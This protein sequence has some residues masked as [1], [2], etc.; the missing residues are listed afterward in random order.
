MLVRAVPSSCSVMVV[1]STIAY[2]HMLRFRALLPFFLKSDPWSL[3]QN[4]G[5]N[6]ENW[7]LITE[8]SDLL[9]GRYI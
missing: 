1:W 3:N 8:A 6:L 7:R 5:G 9:A 4:N 2:Y